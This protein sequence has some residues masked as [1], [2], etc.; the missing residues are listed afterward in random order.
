M[1]AHPSYFRFDDINVYN[2]NQAFVSHAWKWDDETPFLWQQAAE[3][4][5][6]QDLQWAH[7]PICQPVPRMGRWGK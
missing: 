7:H 6:E 2:A 3:F 5:Q 1:I 4:T